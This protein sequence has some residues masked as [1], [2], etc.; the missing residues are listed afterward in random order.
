MESSGKDE[1]KPEEKPCDNGPLIE[2]LIKR[3]N[4]ISD[5]VR[6]YTTSE[7]V[8]ENTIPTLTMTS[9]CIIIY[10]YFL[11]LSPSEPWEYIVKYYQI[12]TRCYVLYLLTGNNR[13]S[14]TS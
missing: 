7:L 10:P 8:V 1:E 6:L 14:S 5:S 13:N 12:I 3:C 4:H 11:G 2:T 9:H